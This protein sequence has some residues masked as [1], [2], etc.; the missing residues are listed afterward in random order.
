MA[1][2]TTRYPWSQY[3]TVRP[4]ATQALVTSSADDRGIDTATAPPG[5]AI[6]AAIPTL[7]MIF[8]SVVVTHAVLVSVDV[9]QPT[10]KRRRGG[11]T[12]RWVVD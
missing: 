4:L 5:T 2:D 3:S 1:N 9:F 10:G 6:A 11:S 7:A 8:L 12:Y